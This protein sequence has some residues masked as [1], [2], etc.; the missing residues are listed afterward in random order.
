MSQDELESAARKEEVKIPQSL[1]NDIK[2]LLA[3]QA[4]T[5]KSES[6][7]TI[8]WIPLSAIAL[9]ACL[10]IAAV[11]RFSVAPAPKDTF[12]DPYLAYA[13]VEETFRKISDKM[14]I[15]LEMTSKA[16]ETA[17][18]PLEIINKIKE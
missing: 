9:A 4:V 12:D 8:K 3:V 17:A 14:S 2:S 15:G 7:K 5:E 1:E 16:E 18:K 13:E 6:K 10:A 11:F